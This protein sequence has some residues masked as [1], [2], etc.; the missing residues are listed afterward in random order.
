MSQASCFRDAWR[1]GSAAALNALRSAEWG[2]ADVLRGVNWRVSVPLA[3]DAAA[4]GQEKATPP[5]PVA[6]FELTV[7]RA[8][9]TAVGAPGTRRI[10]FECTQEQLGQLFDDCERIQAQLDALGQQ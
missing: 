8:G 10:A 6:T 1:A 5:A 9:H 7:G 4:G 2:S 3:S